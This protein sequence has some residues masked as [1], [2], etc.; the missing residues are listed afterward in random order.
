MNKKIAIIPVS[1]YSQPADMDTIQIIADKYN[2]ISDIQ[3]DT[4]A[5]Y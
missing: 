1:L 5:L 4:N 2:L 3:R